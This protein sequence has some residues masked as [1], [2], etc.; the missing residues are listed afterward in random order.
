MAFKDILNNFSDFWTSRTKEVSDSI[1][2][3]LFKFRI[4]R[5]Y[6][7]KIKAEFKQFRHAYDKAINP[8]HPDRRELYAF[9]REI[10]LDDEVTS[11]VRTAYM[12][13]QRA[14]FEVM[15]DKKP[16]EDLVELFARPW[17]FDLLEAAVKTECWGHSLIEFNPQMNEAQEFQSFW[18][19]PRDQVRPEYGDVLINQS[20]ATGEPYRD[21]SKFPYLLEMGRPDDLGLYHIVAIPAL[22]KRFA[23]TDWSLFS[24]RFGSPFL[25]IKTSSRDE[26]E[27]AAKEEMAAN[28]G[29]NGFAILDDQDEISTVIGNY[30]G[31]A[32]YTFRD[33][34]DKADQQIAKIING[35]TG[36][37][38]EKAYVGSA[39]V[40]E[41]LLNDYTFSRMYRIQY[42][43]NFQ[44]IPFLI[45]HGYPLDGARFEFCELRKQEE[46]KGATDK[47]A[48]PGK[49][50]ESKPQAKPEDPT[51]KL[52]AMIQTAVT[53]AMQQSRTTEPPRSERSLS[54]QAHYEQYFKGG[55]SCCS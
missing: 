55:Q 32:H 37:S 42:W 5:S 12:T 36:T 11:Q 22:R 20:D 29:S 25:T 44:L 40:H 7:W 45:R 27:L 33:R 26:K 3:K 51:E 1:K 21:A 39:Q 6:I 34:M 9:Y 47:P 30:T 54:F 16:N 38:E 10:E 49:P 31:T 14:P 4:T 43:I 13:V 17:F 41:R 19:L 24:E 15:K 53:L 18:I 46:E 2:K 50:G 52:S 28:F 23:D 48:E 8:V 35:Q